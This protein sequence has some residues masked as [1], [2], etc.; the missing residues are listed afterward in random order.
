LPECSETDNRFVFKKART[1][2]SAGFF[3]ALMAFFHISYLTQS[4]VNL[5]YFNVKIGTLDIYGVFVSM[6]KKFF[7]SYLI[8]FQQVAFRHFFEW[9][10]SV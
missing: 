5:G 8:C 6:S 3:V 7:A 2:K 4:L 1:V 9:R 10:F